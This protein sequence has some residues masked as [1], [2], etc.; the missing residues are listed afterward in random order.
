[1][2][3]DAIQSGNGIEG[4]RQLE[5]PERAL[6]PH[7]VRVAMRAASLTFRDLMVARGG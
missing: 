5:R 6:G 3:C 2:R 4:L 7:E 1:M